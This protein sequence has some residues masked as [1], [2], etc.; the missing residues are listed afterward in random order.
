M[1]SPKH[2]GGI[3]AGSRVCTSA[4]AIPLQR[5]HHAGIDLGR[6]HGIEANV[7]GAASIA[8][9]RAGPTMA[10]FAVRQGAMFELP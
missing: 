7:R 8:A 1:E 9:P 10:C 4:G 6:T 2:A 3:E 5:T